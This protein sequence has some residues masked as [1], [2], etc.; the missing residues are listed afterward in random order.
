MSKIIVIGEMSKIIVIGDIH[1][2]AIWK[3]IIDDNPDA[4]KF[5]FLGDYFDSH[6]KQYHPTRQLFNFNEIL[7]IQTEF[8]RDKIILLLGNH[9]YHYLNNIEKYSGYNPM[10]YVNVHQP[11]LDAYNAGNIKIIHIED[12]FL[13]SHAGVS[14][15]WLYN[16]SGL[17]E[18]SLINDPETFDHRTLKWNDI[19]GYN[20]YGDTISNSPIWIRPYSLTKNKLKDFIHIVGHT[21]IPEDKM[22]ENFY[23]MGEKYGIYLNDLLPHHYMIIE[24]NIIKYEKIEFNGSDVMEA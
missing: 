3:K 24:N 5:I 6:N 9:D 14:E 12:N 21:T 18:L 2:R 7:K 11:L 15:Y 10:T 16:I 1:G 8:G 23:S 19:I 20:A 17:S 13:F 22:D 4:D